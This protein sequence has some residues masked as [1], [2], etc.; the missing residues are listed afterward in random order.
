MSISGSGVIIQNGEESSLVVEIKKKQ[1]SYPI[2]LKHKGAV[3][4]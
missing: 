2:L 1:D 3:H 4:N